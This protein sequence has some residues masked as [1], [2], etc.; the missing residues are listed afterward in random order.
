MGADD[1]GALA[2]G[3]FLRRLRFGCSV[4]AVIIVDRFVV[5]AI[6]N[7]LQ[8]AD[9]FFVFTGHFSDQSRLKTRAISINTVGC[10]AGLIGGDTN[11][12]S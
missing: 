4:M 12:A 7:S 10:R 8:V 1:V 2:M 3:C 11:R 5:G 6:T 9:P